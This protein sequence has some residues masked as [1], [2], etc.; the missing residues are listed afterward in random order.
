M[1]ESMPK[2]NGKDVEEKILTAAI[3]VFL[4]NG[5][6][7]TRMQAIAD[8]AGV[9]KALLH[10][11][12]RSKQNLYRA[13]VKKVVEKFILSLIQNLDMSLNFKGI[14]KNFIFNHIDF[15]RSNKQVLQFF[16]GEVW[17]NSTEVMQEF[18]A[19]MKIQDKPAF[20]VLM[21]RIEKAIKDKE[22]KEGDPFSLL[23]NIL[24]LD[25]F[26][27]LLSPMFLEMAGYNEE[28]KLLVLNNRAE[29]VYN[30]VWNSI[31]LGMEE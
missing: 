22:I 18:Q 8:E 9:N 26:F 1:E 12:F 6:S 27:F 30:F 5:K 24:S 3:S 14:L 4:R 13:V 23:V 20:M 21:D 29:E 28:K 17:M 25:L 19:A 16:M 2:N 31:K 11:Y 10:Y 15:I 7:G